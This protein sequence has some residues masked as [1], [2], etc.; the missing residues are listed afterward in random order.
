MK[1]FRLLILCIFVLLLMPLS[2]EAQNTNIQG[3]EIK[4]TGT[5]INESVLYLQAY[6]G[7]EKF[8]FDSAKVKGR[9]TVVFKNKKKEMPSGIY[10]ITDRAGNEYI[11]LMIDQNRRFSITGGEWNNHYYATAIAEGS[12]ENTQ[13]LEFQ[14][15]F[16]TKDVLKA[17]AVIYTYY[18]SMP[19][20]LLGHYLQ[21]AFNIN[22]LIPKWYELEDTISDIYQLLADHYLDVYTFEDPRLMH[23]PINPE[24]DYYF[25]DILSQDSQLITRY[26]DQFLNRIK[27]KEA[28]EY[29]LAKL[30]NMFD[31]C[32]SSMVCDQ[33]FVYLFD[34]YC[35]NKNISSI[36]EDLSRYYQRSADRKRRLLPGNT[37]PALVSY[38][39]TNAKHSSGDIDK[40]YIILWFWDADC[41]ECIVET[42][43]LDEFYKEFANHYNLEV[44]AVA[45]TD[46]LEKWDNFCKKHELSWVNVNYYLNDPNYDFIEYFDLITTPVIYLLDKKHT[47]ITRNFPLEEIH[48]KLRIKE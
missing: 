6:Y 16:R 13:F 21:A 7:Q 8:L 31:H 32:T 9:K 28:Q 46:D 27:D 5:E 29:Y 17:T 35:A 20:S 39:I 25:F 10:S 33:V 3:Y 23:C 12:D 37:V 26:A 44:F 22:P 36:S 43:K 19:A 2:L 48:E 38:D 47:I 24:L 42:P 41:D 34:K 40:D 18:E 11:D 1:T 45:I 14:K 15:Q 4:I 30:L